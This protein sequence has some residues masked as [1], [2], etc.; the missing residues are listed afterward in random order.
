MS[1][2]EKPSIIYLL[3]LFLFS[4]FAHQKNKIIEN[5]GNA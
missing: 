1:N 5:Y 4:T 3:I 2:I